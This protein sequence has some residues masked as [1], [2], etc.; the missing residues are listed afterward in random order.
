MT[1]KEAV[2]RGPVRGSRRPAVAGLAGTSAATVATAVLHT[3]WRGVPFPPAAIA[4]ILVRTTPGGFDTFFI[5]RLGH[6]AQRL[7]LL[8]TA[9]AFALSGVVLGALVG[10]IRPRSLAAW[11]ASLLPLWAASFAL[12]PSTPQY[13]SRGS[14]ALVTLPLWLL[15]GAFA[16]RI[17]TRLERSPEIEPRRSAPRDPTRRVALKAVGFGGAGVLL[18]LANLSELIFRRPD[19]G[20]ELFH[21]PK[22]ARAASPPAAP[23]DADFAHIAGL[24]KEVTS[25]AAH[26]VVDEEI[27]DPDIDPKTWRLTVS[28]LVDEP[29]SLTYEDL[30][31]YPVVERYQTLECISNKIGGHLISTARWIGVP[32][33]LILEDAG[34]KDG[35]VE[36]VFRASG[37]YSD[38]HAIEVALDDSTL[39]AVGMNGHVLP[40]AHG[41]PA[42]LLTVGT[43]GMKNPK[44]LTG[45]EVVDRPYQGFWEQ[46]GWTKAAIVKTGTRIDV[47]RGG[48]PDSGDVTVAGVSFAGDRG[49]SR[50]EVS[51]DGGDTWHEARLKTPLSDVAWTLWLYRFTPAA[52]DRGPIVAR[53]YD[54]AG[55]VQDAAV[56]AP[57]PS[58]ATG[59]ASVP[60]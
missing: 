46:R 58:G 42:R 18:G 33:H 36:V 51:T 17:H 45:I 21:S 30:R 60:I 39:I 31:A 34:V 27:I 47:P 20:R 2:D 14:Y 43:Y 37:G 26:Y 4:Q 24:T 48:A 55:R 59:Y 44:W 15:A 11:T 57:Y 56:A 35:A 8:G 28:G 23:G 13:V 38:S 25:T 1:T 32:L 29:M 10:R 19:P 16:G 6:W 50:V 52:S 7:A 54:G 3:F 40:R 53:A 22:L 12:Y 9:L 49:I 5:D 41:F